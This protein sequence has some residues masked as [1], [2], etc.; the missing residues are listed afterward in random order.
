MN[1]Q[2]RSFLLLLGILCAAGSESSLRGTSGD[3][4]A[5][6]VETVT[7]NVLRKMKEARENHIQEETEDGE[8][9]DLMSQPYGKQGP[10]TMADQIIGNPQLSVVAELS[11][12]CMLGGFANPRQSFTLFAP[13]DHAFSLV[14]EAAVTSLIASKDICNYMLYHTLQGRLF[15][16]SQ[17][18]NNGLPKQTLHGKFITTETRQTGGGRIIKMVNGYSRLA[19]P[20]GSGARSANGVIHVINQVLVP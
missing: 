4:K 12:F 7:A 3:E 16:D 10:L 11:A 18:W 20:Y 6:D 14:G 9:R 5:P 13:T 2:L 19:Y 1:S 8:H 17:S 15:S